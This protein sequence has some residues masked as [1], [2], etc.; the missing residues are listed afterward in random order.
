MKKAKLGANLHASRIMNF[1][2]VS[3]ATLVVSLTIGAGSLANGADF[4]ARSAWIAPPDSAPQAYGVYLFRNTFELADVPTQFDVHV[5]ADQR[6]RLYANGVEVA[7]GPSPGNLKRW[8]FE[9]VDL[10]PFLHVRQKYTFR[11]RVEH[12]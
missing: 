3:F 5:S 11:R 4:D 6:Y 8:R 12:G 9:T 7:F 10:A 2:L 1:R